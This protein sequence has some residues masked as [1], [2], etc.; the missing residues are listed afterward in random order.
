MNLS[1]PAL[2]WIGWYVFIVCL[3]VFTVVLPW[4][5]THRITLHPYVSVG[6]GNWSVHC[7]LQSRPHQGQALFCYILF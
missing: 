4:A 7:D 3:F 6:C 2:C 5:T 1:V